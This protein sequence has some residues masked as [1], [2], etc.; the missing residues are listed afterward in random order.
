MVRR[1]QRELK[2]DGFYHGRIDGISGPE[3]HAALR[4]YQRDN[5]LSATGR[6]D[7]ATLRQLGVRT[8]MGAAARSSQPCNMSQTSGNSPG[9]GMNNPNTSANRVNSPSANLSKTTIKAAQNELKQNGVYSGPIN[10]NW[11]S[12]TQTAVRDYQ[13]KSN[14]NVTGELDEPTLKA[15]GVSNPSSEPT[16]QPQQ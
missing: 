15:L 13:Q 6:L 5:K 4:A 8:R 9:M 1:A 2:A 10:G 14:L 12:A 3:T 16:P 7:S 11:D